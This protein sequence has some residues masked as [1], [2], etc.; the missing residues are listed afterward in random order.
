MPVPVIAFA[1]AGAVLGGIRQRGQ[2]KA[3]KKA[4]L[5]A[6]GQLNI[7]VNQAKLQFADQVKRR[8]AV[9]QMMISEARNRFG[10]Q[11]GLSISERLAAMA[12]DMTVDTEALKAG[13]EATLSDIQFEKMRIAAGA[14]AQSGSVGL[15]A[16]E[17]GIQ[18]AQ[19]AQSL[20]A[21]LA[22]GKQ[23]KT[24]GALLKKQGSAFAG[25]GGFKNSIAT[26]QVSSLWPTITGIARQMRAFQAIS[27]GAT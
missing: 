19:L 4:A 12:A 20:N 26:M 18:G 17:G 6:Q 7:R 21:S 24:A 1:V 14:E 15:A 16:I 13:I 11:T 25:L 3:L 5:L 9:G 27:Q 10:A 23:A 2:N 8:S 22:A